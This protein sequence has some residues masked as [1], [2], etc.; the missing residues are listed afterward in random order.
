MPQARV[1]GRPCVLLVSDVALVCRRS[2]GTI[3][4][5]QVSDLRKREARG[6]GVNPIARLADDHQYL[7]AVALAVAVLHAAVPNRAYTS[8]AKNFGSAVSAVVQR[9]KGRRP[10][11]VRRAAAEGE[12][13]DLARPRHSER[14]H[15]N[16]KELAR[17]GYIH[18]ALAVKGHPTWAVQPAHD[19]GDRPASARGRDSSTGK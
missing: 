1:L 9:V 12:F 14:S 5:V 15:I 10:Q 17:L 13:V 8:R 11:T 2:T 16:W 3:Q 4:P 6:G 19:R 18:A 7:A